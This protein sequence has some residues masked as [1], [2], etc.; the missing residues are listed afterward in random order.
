MRFIYALLFL[1][2]ILQ[3]DPSFAQ[4]AQNPVLQ[5]LGG[6]EKD[7]QKRDNK[8]YPTL[9]PSP[10]ELRKTGTG[11]V[12]AIID[13]LRL[14]LDDRRI[15]FLTGL[16]IP[17]MHQLEPGDLSFAAIDLMKKLFLDKKVN[18]YQNPDTRADTKNRMGNE[19]AHITLLDN[20]LW[21][22]GALIAEGLARVRTTLDSRFIAAEMLQLEDIAR[23]NAPE[24]PAEDSEEQEKPAPYIWNMEEYKLFDTDS[25][26]NVSKGYHIVEGVV[27][28]SAINNNRIFLNF[29]QNWRNDF[30]VAIK[31]ESRRLFSKEGFEPLKWQGRTLRVRGWLQEYNGPYIEIDH[32]ERIEFIDNDMPKATSGMNTFSTLQKRQN[33]QEKEPV[34][35]ALPKINELKFER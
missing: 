8:T 6:E 10:K 9:V 27:Q 5:K 32:P 34:K 17:D 29:G 25:V 22:Q 19:I 21:A 28:K 13:P 23:K 35:D 12:A 18:I 4:R 2:A 3:I 7:P 16:D 26:L 11:R 30:T 33:T 15:I 14:Q 31:P 24:R 1:T 20:D